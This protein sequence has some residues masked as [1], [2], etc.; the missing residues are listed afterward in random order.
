MCQ[1]MCIEIYVY[2]Y[3]YECV[4]QQIYVYK[5]YVYIM[6]MFID[7]F[8]HMFIYIYIYRE[9][10][11]IDICIIYPHIPKHANITYQRTGRDTPW[12]DLFPL[13]SSTITFLGGNS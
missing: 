10:F 5:K 12:E 6:D 3:V 7:M 11:V 2:Q 4:Y 1:S 13:C 9:R 8:M